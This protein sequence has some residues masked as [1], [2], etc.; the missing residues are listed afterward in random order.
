MAD[1]YGMT[2]LFEKSMRELN[3]VE[4]AKKLQNSPEYQKLSKDAKAE[5]LDRLFKM[6]WWANRSGFSKFSKLPN[7]LL[8]NDF[9]HAPSD[10]DIY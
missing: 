3:T 7:L 6:V 1:K 10:E 2:K 9:T 4:K 5:I 8:A